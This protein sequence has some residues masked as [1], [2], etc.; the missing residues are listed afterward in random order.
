MSRQNTINLIAAMSSITV[1]G[2]V[3]GFIFPVL[4]LLMEKQGIDS[5]LIGINTA[6]QPVGTVATLFLTA[7][8]VGRFGA[9]RVAALCVVMII[10]ALLLYPHLPVFWYW[11]VLRFV[12]GFFFT[13]LFTISEAWVVKYST[14]PYASRILSIY[15]SL[16]ALAMAAGPL[17]PA[18]I[19]I[20]GSALFIITAIV[21]L[22]A[23]L[24]I[25]FVKAEE[26]RIESA[27]SLTDILNFVWESPMLLT[28]VGL[29]A[30]CEAAALSFLPLLGVFNGLYADQAAVLVSAFVGGPIVLQYPIGW[31]AHKYGKFRVFLG[32]ALCTAIALLAIPLLILNVLI[33]PILA[34]A[35]AASAGLYTLALAVLGERYS[36]NQILVG[37]SAFSAIYGIGML[38]G[39]V[40]CGLIMNSFGGACIFYGLAALF[41]G[42][43]VAIKFKAHAF[44]D[45]PIS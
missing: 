39:S 9:V 16:F 14:G 18:Q 31:L 4:S 44:A 11:F 17:L 30:A 3:L 40:L 22:V 10:A 5:R 15:M 34:I 7:P 36:G 25:A 43:A 26:A 45:A 21:I 12:Q 29:F 42:F 1:L 23:A 38:A 41:A 32:C 35:G 13:T 28:S 27:V 33:W 6:V 2:F 20:E 24:P 19:G 8:I 37:T